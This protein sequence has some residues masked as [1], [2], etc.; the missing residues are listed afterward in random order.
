MTT[1]REIARSNAFSQVRSFDECARFHVWHSRLGV[2]EPI[3]RQVQEAMSAGRGHAVVGPSG[4]GKTS[5]LAAAISATDGLEP[6][7]L[8]LR[9]SVAGADAAL[10]QDPRFLA[11]RL[12]RAI[13]RMSAEAEALVERVASSATVSGA[14]ETW[15]GQLGGGALK[16][17]K[18]VR[19]RTES[20]DFERT[21]EEVLDVLVG[22]VALLTENGLRP[23]V[24]LEDADGL[25]RLPGM[26]D[27]ERHETADGFFLSGLDPILRV[28]TLPPVIAVQPDYLR[29]EGFRRVA[30]HFDGAGTV[31]SPSQLSSSAVQLLLGERLWRRL[32]MRPLTRSSLTKALAFFSTTDSRSRRC[33][34]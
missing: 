2:A 23:V 19:R 24:L 21:P 4:S 26:S 22:A 27:E 13:A 12:V 6:A 8:P 28:V 7:R 16:I 10:L 1:L 5:T 17:A 33:G 3:D 18:E 14:A 30:A 20:F 29:L 32:L 15:R 9:L 11:A 34:N 25:L 31:P